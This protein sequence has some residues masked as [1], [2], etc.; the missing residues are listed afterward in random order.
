MAAN[1][2][3]TAASFS[4]LRR[5]PPTSVLWVMVLECSFSTTGKPSAS[6]AATAS[7]TVATT[8]VSTVGIP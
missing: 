1:A 2:A 6:A 5:T 7:S 3:R 4:R 8:R